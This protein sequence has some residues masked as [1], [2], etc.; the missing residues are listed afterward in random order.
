MFGVPAIGKIIWPFIESCII[1]DK[2]AGKANIFHF[3]TSKLE[4][5][6]LPLPFNL[7][8]T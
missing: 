5:C 3:D 1:E 6:K 2:P 8:Y 4:N 7:S